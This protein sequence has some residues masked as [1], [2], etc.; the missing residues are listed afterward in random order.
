MSNRKITVRRR[1]GGKHAAPRPQR[2][3]SPGAARVPR[4]AI[5]TAQGGIALALVLSM[6]AVVV[7]T[8]AEP[9][10]AAVAGDDSSLTRAAAARAADAY[11]AQLRAQAVEAAQA[12]VDEAVAVRADAAEAAVPDELLAELD[13]ATAELQA[14]MADVEIPE[15]VERSRSASRDAERGEQDVVDTG[16]AQ[17]TDATVD[18]ADGATA[19]DAAA[20]EAAAAAA[21]APAPDAPAEP[22]PAEEDASDRIAD[23][24]L[25]PT[26][27]PGTTPLR[28]ALDRVKE[29]AEVVSGTADQ[30]R[31]EAAAAQAAA[32]AAAQAAAQA[33]AEEAARVAAEKEAQRAAWKVSLQGYANGR[34]PDEALCG[35][36]FDGNARL[37]CDAAEALEALNAAFAAHFGRPLY[38]TDSYRS[39]GAQV[40][41]RANKGGLC[42]APGTSNHGWGLAVDLAGGVQGFGTAEHQW[43]RENAASFQW[44][45]PA[46]AQA[47]GSKPEPWHWEYVG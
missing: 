46:W 38:V 6:G 39:Y 27:D 26:T 24:T 8:D 37:R 15:I 47:G 5:R 18:P 43:M 3:A 1:T 34:I 2:P 33:A 14:A 19:E 11:T 40:A 16:T 32:E 36:S 21:E 23:V 13:A 25:P 4:V 29:A 31:A 45:H 7:T 17:T 20:A 41:C 44:V 9:S 10:V 35:V 12:A 42:A 30:K 28:A 22:A